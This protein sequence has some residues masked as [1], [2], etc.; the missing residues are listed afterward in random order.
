MELYNTILWKSSI[1]I[2]LFYFFYK[3]FLQSETYFK[4][5]RFFLL[6]GI[7][8]SFLLPLIIVTKYIETDDPY[9]TTL[10]SSH[11]TITTEYQNTEQPI[12]YI[13]ILFSGYVIISLI[14]FTRFIV[15][16]VA[17]TLLIKK[18]TMHKVGNINYVEIQRNISP[19]SFFNTIVYNTNQFSASELEQIITHEKAHVYQK[20]SIDNLLST[21]L[22]T[23]L[24][25]N[26]FAWLLKKNF[27]KI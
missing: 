2:T 6:F 15:H 3:A 8:I 11:Q 25:F 27:V 9:F 12:D 14:L 5:I 18:G 20:H 1:V 26:P 7:A 19:F 22:T 21:F 13:K 17:I 16:L 10:S 24:W 23:I 4:S